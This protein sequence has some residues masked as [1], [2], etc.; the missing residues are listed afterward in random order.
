MMAGCLWALILSRRSKGKLATRLSRAVLAWPFVLLL[1]PVIF[2]W[3]GVILGKFGNLTAQAVLETAG[4]SMGGSA[5]LP[6][7][8]ISDFL[9]LVLWGPAKVVLFVVSPVPW[10][11]RSPE[12]A[13]AFLADGLI[14]LVAMLLI[15]RAPWKSPRSGRRRVVQVLSMSIAAAVVIFSI[16]TYNA[17]TAMRHR[18]KLL[19]P[20][21]LVSVLAFEERRSMS[22]GGKIGLELGR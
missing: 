19:A 5:Y 18:H 14:F 20:I 11:W 4:R 16:G 8:E 1:G 12:D 15:L 21:V 2:Q 6:N 7:V 3:R 22:L 13:V 9:D 17:G 10:Q